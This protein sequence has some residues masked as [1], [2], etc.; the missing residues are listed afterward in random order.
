MSVK[1]RILLLIAVTMLS[2]TLWQTPSHAEDCG[3]A[4]ECGKRLAE[5]QLRAFQEW[6]EGIP[7]YDKRLYDRVKAL[8]A[9]NLDII[10]ITSIGLGVVFFS[11]PIWMW[12]VLRLMGFTPSR[13]DEAG[14]T[15]RPPEKRHTL[16]SIY[17]ATKAY[18]LE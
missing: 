5:E 4:T 14:G 12:V 15:P 13:R 7:D 1:L 17:E 8:Q 3:P 18:L 11:I 16:S 2:F 9:R 10:R 6:R